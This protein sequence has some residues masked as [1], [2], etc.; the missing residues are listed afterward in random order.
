MNNPVYAL[1]VSDSDVYAGGQFWSADG[2]TVNFIAKWN[3]S[4]WTALGSG[5]NHYVYALAVSGNDLYVGGSFTTAGGKVSGY[6]ARAASII[7]VPL[8]IVT[9]DGFF[10]FTN[11]QFRFS[12]TGPAGS[13]AVI[14][15]S[16]NLQTWI[17][18]QTN[19][20]AGGALLFTDT[21]TT[22]YPRRVYRAV[23]RP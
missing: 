8:V 12:L 6:A 17:S 11:R 19:S 3:G 4:T 5:M 10:G 15:A 7:S 20:L 13:N 23:L 1:T 16:T 22:N 18:L 9:T 21:K 14:Q 2:N